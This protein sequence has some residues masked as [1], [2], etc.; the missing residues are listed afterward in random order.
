MGSKA[1]IIL[2]GLYSNFDAFS[3]CTEVVC[4]LMKPKLS[5]MQVCIVISIITG[6]TGRVS[7]KLVHTGIHLLYKT[8]FTF[9]N[10]SSSCACTQR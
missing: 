3:C 4:A 6:E 1:G 10:C 8:Y 2:L 5:I 9:K 7:F